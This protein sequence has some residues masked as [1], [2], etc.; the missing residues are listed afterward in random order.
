ML[1]TP[2]VQPTTE[3]PETALIRS[4]AQ[5]QALSRTSNQQTMLE[6]RNSYERHSV[7]SQYVTENSQKWQQN[8]EPTLG[9]TSAHNQVI[10]LSG[11][12]VQSL[13]R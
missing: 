7:A 12:D 4:L 3:R 10:F 6:E 8:G 1:R 2:V 5:R 9:T 11:K 13:T